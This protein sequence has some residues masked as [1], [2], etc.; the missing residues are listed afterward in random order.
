M[1]SSDVTVYVIMMSCDV[2]DDIILL[3]M[4]SHD[5]SLSQLTDYQLNNRLVTTVQRFHNALGQ[6]CDAMKK[7]G[8][9]H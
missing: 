7:V 4:M 8:H 6:A 1:T 9:T 3:I 5:P 2:T